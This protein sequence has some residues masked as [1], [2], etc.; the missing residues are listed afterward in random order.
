MIKGLFDN[1]MPREKLINY[2][3]ENL[4]E[5]ELFAII[6][7]TGNKNKNVIELSRE[8][9]EKIKNLNLTNITYHELLEING[10]NKAKASQI[11]SVL[12]IAKRINN[13]TTSK[14][15]KLKNS[16]DAYKIVKHEMQILKEEIVIALYTN[17]RNHII[18]KEIISKGGINYS[19]IDQRIII[20]KAILLGAAG[21]FLFH[22]HPSG[23][24]TPSLE[25][26]ALTKKIKQSCKLFDIVFLD[27]II[28]GDEC[29][30]SMFDND[31][32][33]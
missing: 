17:N 31:T 11:I 10:I 4:T 2:G 30:Y 27:H 21:F 3:A 15:I 18:K 9:I 5:T 14:K 1:E 8:I 19:I 26:K 20:K 22:N 25:D 32:L 29:Y 16:E 7:R 13:K 23:D 6:L 24:P 33:V 28:I 12:E